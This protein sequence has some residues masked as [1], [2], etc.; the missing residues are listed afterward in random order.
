[1][2]IYPFLCCPTLIWNFF[3]LLSQEHISY[4]KHQIVVHFLVH[5]RVA[6]EKRWQKRIG[7]ES[8]ILH[9][10]SDVLLTICRMSVVI[11]SSWNVS[12]QTL[13]IRHCSG[14]SCWYLCVLWWFSNWR[15]MEFGFNVWTN[16][17]LIVRCWLV[18]VLAPFTRV[19]GF[20]TWIL[21]AALC[22]DVL[23]YDSQKR[24]R[25]CEWLILLLIQ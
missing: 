20:P 19:S 10:I 4:L 24:S 15:L 16:F 25:L 23:I 14:S 6:Y 8:R 18:S 13:Y 22:E 2:R 21:S 7:N 9:S 11:V 5:F 1:M 17:S 12:P 3:L